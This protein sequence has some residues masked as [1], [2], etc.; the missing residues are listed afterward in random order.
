LLTVLGL[1]ER[2]LNQLNVLEKLDKDTWPMVQMYRAAIQC[3]VLR[4]EIFAGRQTPL[5]FGEPPPW[6]ACLL[7]S[8]RLTA[9]TRHDQAAQLRDQ[10][11]DQACPSSGTIDEQ[12]FD[13]I[14]D[15]DSRLG[16]VIELILNGRY[17]WAPFQQIR[18]IKISP[19][20]DLRDL[21]WLPAQFK[22]TNGGEAVGLIPTRYPD[23][24]NT[25]DSAIQL[26][27]TTQW[28]EVPG[29][30]HQGQGQRMLATDQDDYPIL[31][32]QLVEIH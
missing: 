19:P 13:W 21:V 5:I 14:A 26:A 15:A 30:A 16:P 4:A 7:E 9:D 28:R 23:S 17:Y 20:E 2:A 18:L 3:E 29:G 27:R 8:L 31:E 11:F 22:W 12:P 24:E 1:W 25:E 6:M 10:A 32:V